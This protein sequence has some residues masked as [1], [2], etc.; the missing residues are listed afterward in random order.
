ML[1]TLV[2]AMVIAALPTLVF[3]AAAAVM[4]KASNLEH[5]DQVVG[6]TAAPADRQPLHFRLGYST[7]EVSRYWAAIVA[8]DIALEAERR[9]LHLDLVFPVAYGAGLGTA[10]LMAW[11]LLRRSFSRVWLVA[12][13]AITLLADWTENLVQ[14]AQLRRYVAAGA[15]GLQDGWIRLASGATIVKLVS[16]AG[17][18]LL[19][20]S[21]L[22]MAVCSHRPAQEP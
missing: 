4:S 17:A 3:F 14:L 12:P 13:V 16:F 7:D 9:F 2:Q 6:V 1:K 5:V 15:S 20:V 8:D 22:I 11:S 10:L 21:L 18:S 19:M